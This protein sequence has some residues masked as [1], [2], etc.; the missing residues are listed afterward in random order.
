VLLGV[1]VF[2][3]LLVTELAVIDEPADRRSGVGRDLNKV[4]A[5]GAGHVDGFAELKNAKLAAVLTNNPDFAG[6]DFSIYPDEWTGGIRRTWGE[7]AA[8]GTLN[9]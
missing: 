9:G 8:Q 4:N 2:L 3:R 5:L 6:T 7:R 1:L